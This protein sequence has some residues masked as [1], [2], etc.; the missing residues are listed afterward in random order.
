MDAM[1]SRAEEIIYYRPADTEDADYVHTM[2]EYAHAAGE[3][4]VTASERYAKEQLVSSKKTTFGDS[5]V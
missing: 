2:P 5:S 3:S 4:T 1:G